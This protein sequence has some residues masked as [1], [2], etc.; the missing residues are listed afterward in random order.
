MT[1]ESVSNGTIP[2]GSSPSAPR[3]IARKGAAKTR[4]AHSPA[5]GALAQFG[6]PGLVPICGPARRHAVPSPGGALSADRNRA[7][8]IARQGRL[9]A[10]V[11]VF[12]SEGRIRVSCR[13]HR[14]KC[15][16]PG[17][18]NSLRGT[19]SRRRWQAAGLFREMGSSCRC[20]SVPVALQPVLSRSCHPF[21]PTTAHRRE[22]RPDPT[23]VRLSCG[24]LEKSG[25]RSVCYG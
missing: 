3:R 2:G 24:I 11:G 14:D 17:S 20:S 4:R 23:S 9:P 7:G 21:V 10:P 12:L 25:L 16:A 18:A 15:R 19:G 13:S 5:P 6:G 1:A 8:G 22:Q